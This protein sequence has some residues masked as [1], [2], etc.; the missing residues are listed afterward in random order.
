[1]RINLRAGLGDEVASTALV[2]EYKRVHPDEM[3]RI[4][5]LNFRELYFHNP[6]INWGNKENGRLHRLQI[7]WHEGLGNICVSFA[8]QCEIEI[9][10]PTPE[11]FI[12]KEE[13]ARAA[14]HLSLGI[15]SG[16]TIVAV[17]TG[18]TWPSRRWPQDRWM[19][20]AHLLRRSGYWLV[21]IGKG[22]G[23]RYG[24]E[25]TTPIECDQT[26][27]DNLDVRGTAALL[28]MCDLVVCHDS[29]TFHLAAAVGTPQ[30][31]TF[32][33]KR[34]EER[35]YWNTTP[36]QIVDRCQKTCNE[37]CTAGKDFCLG[38]IS[39]ARMFNAVEIARFRFV[40]R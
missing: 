4:E 40:G 27:K 1:M 3:I 19:E 22:G 37:M 5:K 10:N 16:K 31:T 7:H 12:T 9:L 32:G 23:D 11:I 8:K 26:M 38:K 14:A 24:F 33:L 30:V 13:E 35:G 25:M 39:A 20:F 28:K 21:E 15:Q 34:F 6:W 36:V 2:R 29:G 17:D 18:A